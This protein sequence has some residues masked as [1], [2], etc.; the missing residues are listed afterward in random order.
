MHRRVK[1]KDEIIQR[2]EKWMIKDPAMQKGKWKETFLNEG[3]LYLEIGSGKGQFITKLAIQNP[4]KNFIAAEGGDKIFVRILQKVE[5]IEAKNLMVITEYMS[6]LDSV[7]SPGE[8]AGIYLNFCDPWPK[9]RHA[10]RRLTHRDM[11]KQYRLIA[12]E[13]ALLA[14]K[15]DNQNLFEFSMEEFSIAGLKILATTQDLHHSVYA[16][17]NITTEYEDKFVSRG[18]PIFYT[19]AAL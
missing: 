2:C 1:H 16:V 14:F 18:C 11:L 12:Q 7:F 9:E 8:I 17:D 3:D 10:K 6:K 15:T 5:Q 4:S 13:G 19:L